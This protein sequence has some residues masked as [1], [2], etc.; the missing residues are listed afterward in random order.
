MRLDHLGDGSILHLSLWE[1]NIILTLVSV[2]TLFILFPESVDGRRQGRPWDAQE[3][4]HSS[5]LAVNRRTMDA[6]GRLLPQV[7][8]D[9]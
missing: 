7:E 5:R 8:A 2:N 4:V 1:N 3:D 9:E 6:K